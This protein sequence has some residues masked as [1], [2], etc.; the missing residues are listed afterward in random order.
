MS[1]VSNS[2]IPFL[3]NAVLA[4]KHYLSLK[5]YLS[6]KTNELSLKTNE[7]SLKTNEL[8]LKT[9]SAFLQERLSIHFSYTI[10]HSA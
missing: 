5:M 2:L 6:L 9:N 10:A 8:S 3:W 1:H 7:L 4:E